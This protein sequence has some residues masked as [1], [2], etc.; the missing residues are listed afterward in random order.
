VV[1]INSPTNVQR[2]PPQGR[3]A[4]QE[5]QAFT[6]IKGAGMGCT[7]QVNIHR[8]GFKLLAGSK[9]QSGFV[10]QANADLG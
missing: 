1:K 5:S 10:V 6:R 4:A 8:F 7:G 9:I 2:N 3:A